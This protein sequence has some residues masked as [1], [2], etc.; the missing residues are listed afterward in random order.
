[1]TLVLVHGVP[2]TD[3]IWRPL[4]S[5]LK[6]LGHEDVVTLSPPGFGAPFPE[7]FVPD[8]MRYREWLVE[9]LSEFDQPVDLFG[10]DF[11]GG[12]V[13]GVAMDRPDLIRSWGIDIIGMLEPDYVWHPA[14]QTWQ[15]PGVGE[16]SI[17]AL[18]G[19]SI[20]DRAKSMNEWGI[21]SP[22]AE[23]VAA[24]QDAD[25]AQAILSLY[26]SV[27][28]PRLAEIGEGLAAARARPGL[29]I[30]ATEDTAVGSVAAR[31]RGA[32]RA[33]ASTLVLEG[34]GHWWMLQ[35]PV[36]GARGLSEFLDGL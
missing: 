2:E 27:A 15:T 35:D 23:Q 8:V 18:F 29:A 1:M 3:A 17:A 33:G 14:A 20:Q 4:I 32:S 13:I 12:H 16:E 6:S 22:T 28:S 26:R 24:H 36:S 31:E 21:P 25:M 19:G 34:L 11:G 10:H 7:D 30:I 9:E 5:E